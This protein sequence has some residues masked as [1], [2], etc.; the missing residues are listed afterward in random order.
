MTILYGMFNA[1]INVSYVLDGCLIIN[2]P[3]Q[4]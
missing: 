4:F 2:V 1:I 3:L